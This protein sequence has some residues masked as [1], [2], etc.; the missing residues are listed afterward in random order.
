MLFSLC[1]LAGNAVGCLLG[2]ATWCRRPSDTSAVVGLVGDHWLG[3]YGYESE[4]CWKGSES[5]TKAG[6][7]ACLPIQSDQ[8]RNMLRGIQ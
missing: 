5:A 8:A 7:I 6:K 3:R 4:Y 1:N 2:N